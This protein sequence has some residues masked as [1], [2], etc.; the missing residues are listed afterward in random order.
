MPE[1]AGPSPTD[2]ARVCVEVG[3]RRSAGSRLSRR[4][5]HQSHGPGPRRA[6]PD[7]AVISV[8]TTGRVA[9][10][11]SAPQ[12]VGLAAQ[13]GRGLNATAG[14]QGSTT[15]AGRG[16]SRNMSARRPDPPHPITAPTASTKIRC[17]TSGKVPA[18][19]PDTPHPIT[20]PTAPTKIRCGTSGK[21]PAS[22]PD[23]P[24]PITA[25]TAS[26]K[27]RC[28]TS[29][30]VPACRPDTPHPIM[31]ERSGPRSGAAGLGD[32]PCESQTCCTRSSPRVADAPRSCGPTRRTKPTA[33][34]VPAG[35]VAA[36]V[37]GSVGS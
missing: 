11:V 10:G 15:M 14:H 26:T 19:H 21:V 36:A 27:I 8:A 37:V 2:T 33:T 23:T 25:P 28:G 22:H 9:G 20:A 5:T 17:G 1:V 3:A 31:S 6:S 34:D 7:I 4:R 35:H 29:G 13:V 18:S 16:R 12:R 30:N 24:H 32:T